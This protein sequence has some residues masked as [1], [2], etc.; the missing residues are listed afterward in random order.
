MFCTITGGWHIG[1]CLYFQVVGGVMRGAWLFMLLLGALQ[2]VSLVLAIASTQHSSHD[3][4][5]HIASKDR[6][7]AMLN[8]NKLLQKQSKYNTS[9]L[10]STRLISVIVSQ[11]DPLSWILQKD[12][13]NPKDEWDP[14]AI[15]NCRGLPD[16]QPHYLVW[17]LSYDK[18]YYWIKWANC[19]MQQCALFCL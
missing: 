16:W 11:A 4:Y 6:L 18:L 19:H 15:S 12:R 13:M 17:F 2:H 8:I 5:S 1:Y 7:H 9:M 3:I 14:S 10:L